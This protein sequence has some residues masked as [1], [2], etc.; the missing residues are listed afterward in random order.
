MTKLPNAR[1]AEI[2]KRKV[3]DYLLSTWNLQGRDKARF[4]LRFGFSPDRW[5]VFAEALKQQAATC[6]VTNSVS[7]LTDGTVWQIV[8]QIQGLPVRHVQRTRTD[9]VQCKPQYLVK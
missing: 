5:S 3:V 1:R 4:F 6:E 9:A 8:W 7:V 2:A